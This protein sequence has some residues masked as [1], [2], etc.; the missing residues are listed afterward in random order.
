MLHEPGTGNRLRGPGSALAA[1]LLPINLFPFACSSQEGSRG[2]AAP[3]KPPLRTWEPTWGKPRAGAEGF[4]NTACAQGQQLDSRDTAW[5]PGEVRRC[6]EDQRPLTSGQVLSGVGGRPCLAVPPCAVFKGCTEW[7]P[8]WKQNQWEVNG[9][10]MWQ[11]DKCEVV[12]T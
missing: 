2:Q 4:G 11:R 6:R 9:M 12:K 8:F 1:A 3:A 7:L 10:P 5:L